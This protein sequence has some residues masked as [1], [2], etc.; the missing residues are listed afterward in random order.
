MLPQE[1]VREF[2]KKIMSMT[3]PFPHGLYH[4]NLTKTAGHP[5][6]SFLA[7]RR[8]HCPR[9]AF[10]FAHWETTLHPDATVAENF[11]MAAGETLFGDI[12]SRELQALAVME[13]AQL[14]ALLPWLPISA[15]A[16]E[17]NQMEKSVAA[18]ACALLA[19]GPS[20]LWD[21]RDGVIEA[22]LLKQIQRLLSQTPRMVLVVTSDES[23]WQEKSQGEFHVTQAQ[24]KRR[25]A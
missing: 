9:A 3:T 19:P 23:V 15:Q 22:V 13:K 24:I 11:L 2:R 1:A 20:V 5:L 4:W 21:A 12:A 14:S 16:L 25:A 18:L 6:K 8:Q 10:A 7:W 17:L